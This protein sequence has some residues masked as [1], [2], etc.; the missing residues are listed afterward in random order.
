MQ[1]NRLLNLL[2]MIYILMFI[3]LIL[4][5]LNMCFFDGEKPKVSKIKC[6]RIF[7]E[8]K[9]AKK[10]NVFNNLKL[11]QKS[12]EFGQTRIWKSWKCGSKLQKSS[13]SF[14]SELWVEK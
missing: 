1:S 7:F 4:F 13:W 5:H 6:F 10:T 14:R 2:V 11:E 12:V 3:F 8:K 9:F